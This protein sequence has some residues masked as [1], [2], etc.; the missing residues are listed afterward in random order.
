MNKVITINLNGKAYQLEE[1]GAEA[2]QHYLEKAKAKLHDNPDQSEI[3]KDFEQAIAEKC[4]KYLSA[5]KN[6]ISKDEVDTI[7]KD[8]GPVTDSESSSA[9]NKDTDRIM[10]RLYRIK[11][12][13]WIAGVCSG[14]AAYFDID[15]K[16][17]RI[18]FFAFALF[19]KGGAIGLYVL[20]AFF[21]P[22]AETNEERA[23]ARGKQF[24]AQEFMEEMKSKYGKY[25]EE[26]YWKQHP[27]AK[28]DYAGMFTGAW[29]KASRIGTGIFTIIGGLVLISIAAAYSI[30]MWAL[31]FHSSIYSNKH[32]MGASPL[33][34]G[35]LITACTYIVALPLKKMVQEARAHTWNIPK[36]KH[37]V[38]NIVH[39]VLWIIAVGFAVSIFIL[40]VPDR[41]TEHAPYGTDF[42][43]GHKEFCIGGNYFCNPQD[44]IDQATI[45]AVEQT[46]HDLGYNLQQ[47]SLLGPSAILKPEMQKLY[48]PYLTPE[49]LKQWQDKPETALGR[50]TSSPYPDSI[51]I[52]KTVKNADGS[53]TVT[54][55]VIEVLEDG[56]HDTTVNYIPVTLTLIQINNEWR[57][58]AIIK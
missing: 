10:K 26:E 24:N 17:V 28:K 8:M 52:D 23:F 29:W 43:I 16:I 36:R 32:L 42:W 38:L 41:N 11:E 13:A 25:G 19:T 34:L 12:G 35:L 40:S 49:L 46:V 33:L 56:E 47:V 39:I 54:G 53:Y 14:I 1:A 3:M 15:V 44:G 31:V 57:I 48:G 6:V 58:S 4:D 2:L 18:V 22:A 7:I 9:E 27:L 37:P 51:S 20:M 50:E 45:N 30:A 21:V 5:H 55:N